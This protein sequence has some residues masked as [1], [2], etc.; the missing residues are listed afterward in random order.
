[1]AKRGTAGADEFGEAGGGRH[2]SK[3]EQEELQRKLQG[4]VKRVGD[5]KAGLS[6]LKNGR[7]GGPASP[8]PEVR[9]GRSMWG[10]GQNGHS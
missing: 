5:F 2:M 6:D 4:K 10:K 8:P 7:K 3:K 9:K 1:M